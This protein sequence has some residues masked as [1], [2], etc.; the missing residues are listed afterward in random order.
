M[1]SFW[2]GSEWVTNR[3]ALSTPAYFED[4]SHMA[5][6]YGGG[7]AADAECGTWAPVI[8]AAASGALLQAWCARSVRVRSVCVR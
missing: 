5:K 1:L 7:A 3:A 4:K 6:W 2:F 8:R